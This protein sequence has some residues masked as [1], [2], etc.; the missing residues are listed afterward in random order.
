MQHIF[1]IVDDTELIYKYATSNNINKRKTIAQYEKAPSDILDILA[2][3]MEKEI[4]LLVLKHK[5]LSKSTMLSMHKDKSEI[6]RIHLAEIVPDEIAVHML[7]DTSAMVTRELA[8]NRKL[9]QKSL[10][11]LSFSKDNETR[12]LVAF[13][14]KTHKKTLQRLLNDTYR[15]TR[16]SLAMNP[17][18]P[19]HILKHLAFDDD[20]KIKIGVILNKTVDKEILKY[21]INDKTEDV[22]LQAQRKLEKLNNQKTRKNRKKR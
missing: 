19:K 20:F 12:R 22:R 21:L 11:H 5:N 7:D 2:H 4:R 17:K 1:D 10:H 18:S 14:T 9:S 3:D 6:V 13:S 8:K 15:E 16:F